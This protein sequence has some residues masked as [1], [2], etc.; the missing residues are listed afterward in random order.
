MTAQ[1]QN[2]H[3][4]ADSGPAYWGRA[5]AIP[6]PRCLCLHCPQRQN[7]ALPGLP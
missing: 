1:A 5:T 4:P 3:V 2:M 7:L 6:Y